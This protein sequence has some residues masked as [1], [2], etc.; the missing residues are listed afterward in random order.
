MHEIAGDVM[1]HAK[2]RFESVVGLF[3][4][5]FKARD[6]I[7]RNGRAE[8]SNNLEIPSPVSPFMSKSPFRKDKKKLMRSKTTVAPG[9]TVEPLTNERPPSRPKAKNDLEVLSVDELHQR[10]VAFM[11]EF[12]EINDNTVD[13]MTEDQERVLDALYKQIKIKKDKEAKEE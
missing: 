10:L 13:T 4:T 5:S 2:T 11:K 8:S 9:I 6:V 12:G 1:S 7:S 3:E